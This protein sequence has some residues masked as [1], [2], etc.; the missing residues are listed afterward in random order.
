MGNLSE[1]CVLRYLVVVNTPVLFGTKGGS[2]VRLPQVVVGSEQ[3]SVASTL[4]DNRGDSSGLLGS[5]WDTLTVRVTSV[6]PAGLS[7]HNTLT[8]T[9]SRHSLDLLQDPV[10]GVT[11][12]DVAVEESVCVDGHVV[13]AATQTWVVDDSNESVNTN[14][15]TIVAGRLQSS[16]T[17]VDVALDLA[18]GGLAG[19]DQLVTDGDGV[20]DR[21]TAVGGN[22][23]GQSA[24]VAS[25][26]ADVED[27]SK[28]LLAGGKSSQ[29]VRNLV[30]V[31]TI[32][33]DGGV[34]LELSKVALDLASRLTAAIGVVRRVGDTLGA[35]EGAGR[36]TGRAGGRSGGS[37]TGGD[38][39]GSGGG[40][41]SWSRSSSGGTGLHGNDDGLDNVLLL[42]LVVL[43]DGLRKGSG[44]QSGGDNRLEQH[45][46]KKLE[47]TRKSLSEK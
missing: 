14:N 37:R 5:T 27:T 39:G 28:D 7:N 2:V 45:V 47:I 46:Y 3:E 24:N 40:G 16:S 32:E 36:G 17:L 9:S 29:N 11:G 19:V 33:S 43:V 20:D 41:S 4:G 25:N 31:H 15:G 18:H 1:R 38:R 35:R 6:W 44:G 26:V 10:T 34:A 12:N 42:V 8:A 30:A 23:R 22:G 21:P 13:T